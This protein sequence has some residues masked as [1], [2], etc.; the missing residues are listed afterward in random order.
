[1]HDRAAHHRGGH[2]RHPRPPG[3]RPSGRAR[4]E[5]L[6]RLGDHDGPQEDR[7]HVPGP[8]LRLLPARRGRGAAH[9]A[10]ARAGRQHAAHAAD[11]QRAVHD[12]RDDDDLPVRRAG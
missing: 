7:D 12:A 9:P 10:A 11:V 4:A 2:R 8:D 3:R 1:G 6:H 5:G